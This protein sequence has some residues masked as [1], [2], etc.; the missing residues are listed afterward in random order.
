MLLGI[1]GIRMS[2]SENLS[3]QRYLGSILS[4]Y[5]GKSTFFSNLIML[6]FATFEC[7]FNFVP[8][9]SSKNAT[10]G[11]NSTWACS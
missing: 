4:F 1:M 7:F 6:H 11:F 9:F 8:V 5:A 2:V 10:F 3:Y